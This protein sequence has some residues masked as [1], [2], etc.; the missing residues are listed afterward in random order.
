M[1]PLYQGLEREEDSPRKQHVLSIVQSLSGETADLVRGYESLFRAYHRLIMQ[2]EASK[3]RKLR[4]PPSFTAKDALAAWSRL[5]V[6]TAS[7][8]VLSAAQLKALPLPAIASFGRDFS[9][10]AT[11]ITA[12]KKVTCFSSRGEEFVQ[13]LKRDEI[14]SDVVVQQLFLLLND[15]LAEERNA[16]Q[17]GLLSRQ[18]LL[19]T[20]KV[21]GGV[22]GE[23]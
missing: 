20:Y 14:R 16:G 5:P 19:R 18:I 6:L 11:G 13:L 22:G 12:P 10:V 8:P 3:G 7:L 21:V 15:L 9:V 2:E 4:L 1:L 23:T 17:D